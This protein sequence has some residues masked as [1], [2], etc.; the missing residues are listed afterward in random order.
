LSYKSE[1]ALG[2]T[3]GTDYVWQSYSSADGIE[4]E[5]NRFES[6][7]ARKKQWSMNI[8]YPLP[9]MLNLPALSVG[10]RDLT[11][12][13]MDHGALYLATSKKVA[14]SSQQRVLFKRV[15]LSVG[16]G[17]GPMG[18]PFAGIETRLALGPTL[19]A[20]IYER[21]PNIGVGLPLLRDLQLNG[22]SLN[23][24]LFYGMSYHWS[25]R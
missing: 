8:E 18:G 4:L 12:T 1:F 10:V 17:T 15:N 14:L 13:G 20:E 23:G 25:L 7:S 6:P 3:P 11:G 2:S 9:T 22:F 19:S 21:R 16:V 24:H 5:I